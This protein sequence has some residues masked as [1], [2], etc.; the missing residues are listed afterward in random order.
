MCD[1]VIAND[2]PIRRPSV[3]VSPQLRDDTLP[4]ATL[5][6]IE[7]V[8]RR[9]AAIEKARDR[10]TRELA[11][12]RRE[13]EDLLP[14]YGGSAHPP[15]TSKRVSETRHLEGEAKREKHSPERE[16]KRPMKAPTPA[17]NKKTTVRTTTVKTTRLRKNLRTEKIRPLADRNRNESKPNPPPT[18]PPHT[19]VG[20]PK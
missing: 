8:R 9:I 13:G 2:S 18:H 6:E 10:R 14:D 11:G 20:R 12:R 3:I 7:A 15:P 1:E 5:E 19:L 4:L 17:R 16:D